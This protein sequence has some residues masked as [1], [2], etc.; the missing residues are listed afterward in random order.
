MRLHAC[1]REL[2]LAHFLEGMRVQKMRLVALLP[3]KMAVQPCR[4]WCSRSSAEPDKCKEDPCME[5][6]EERASCMRILSLDDRCMAG[7]SRVC[8]CVEAR[9]LT[10]KMRCMARKSDPGWT[11]GANGWARPIRSHSSAHATNWRLRR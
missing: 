7:E 8:A 5:I 1:G 10:C 9:Y 11:G 2:V 4:G 3:K 6:V